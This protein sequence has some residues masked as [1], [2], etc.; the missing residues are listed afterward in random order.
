MSGRSNPCR[1]ARWRKAGLSAAALVEI[2]DS[3]DNADAAPANKARENARS[4]NLDVFMASVQ[5]H[6]TVRVAVTADLHITK[7]SQGS[8]HPML[9]AVAD[10][11][12]MLLIAGDLTDH[13]LPEEAQVLARELAAIRTPVV[14]GR[15]GPSAR[16]L[17]SV[18]T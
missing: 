18:S 4:R 12:D 5:S 16:Q 2:C 14:A 9:A 1:G 3:A 6:G 13:G 7:T 15:W 11:A 10:S 8:L 17:T